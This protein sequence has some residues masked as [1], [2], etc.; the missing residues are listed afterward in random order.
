LL[1]DTFTFREGLEVEE[2]IS[3]IRTLYEDD[4]ARAGEARHELHDQHV[5]G[6]ELSDATASVLDADIIDFAEDSNKEDRMSTSR[7][8]MRRILRRVVWIRG[9]VI[10]LEA[11]VSPSE[12]ELVGLSEKDVPKRQAP[13][14]TMSI[15]LMELFCSYMRHILL[16][17]VEEGAPSCKANS[18]HEFTDLGPSF[19]GSGPCED[20]RDTKRIRLKLCPICVRVS[21]SRDDSHAYSTWASR[22]LCVLVM[23]IGG[24]QAELVQ[25]GRAKVFREA[26]HEAIGGE[27]DR[28]CAAS[29]VAAAPLCWFRNRTVAADGR[30]AL[31]GVDDTVVSAHVTRAAALLDMGT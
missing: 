8:G 4:S 11:L 21:A 5:Q 24:R 29:S 18:L 1:R 17:V 16:E 15:L 12:E 26:T 7:K 13:K 27:A 19:R 30:E 31:D 6:H 3:C 9:Q 22:A 10:Q 2:F 28:Q 14:V 20:I 25:S 23:S